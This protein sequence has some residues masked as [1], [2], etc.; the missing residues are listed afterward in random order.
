M[1]HLLVLKKHLQKEMKN[2]ERTL[3]ETKVA[4]DNSPSAMESASDMSRSRLE[5][6][7]TMLEHMKR[8]KESL[9]N[10]VPKKNIDSEKIKQWSVAEIE[11]SNNK[12]KVVVVPEGLGGLKISEFQ[13]ISDNTL[14]GAVLIGKKRGDNF[15]FND[16][17]GVVVS[18]NEIL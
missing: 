7:V 15:S 12:M 3:K 1:H 2:L 16:L 11:L 6:T 10:A 9:L 14:L 18:V 17:I 5:G 4:R 8:E 13:Y